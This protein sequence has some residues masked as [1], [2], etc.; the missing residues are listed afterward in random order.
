MSRAE[1]PDP[2]PIARI[3]H[4]GGGTVATFVN[5]P[6]LELRREAVRRAALAALAALDAKLPLEVPMLIGEDVVTGRVFAS[7]DPSS[8]TRIVAHAHEATEAHVDDAV[9]RAE[10]GH[11][12]WSRKPAAERAATLSRAADILRARR[13]ELAALPP[14]GRQAVGR[15]RR[16]RLRG[17]RLPRVLRAGRARAR[18]RQAAAPAAGRAQ[19]AALCRPR[20]H[21]R[22]RAVELPARDRRGHG[23]RRARDRQRGRAQ[24][25]RAGARLRQGRRRR[26]PP[27][28]SRSTRSRCSRAAT[29]PARR[30][31]PTRAS[32]RSSSPAPAPSACRSSSAPRRSSPASVTSSA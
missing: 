16:R 29:R 4:S 19:R 31:S 32:T 22:D 12:A 11:V 30:S 15:G 14:R 2:G 7:V 3:G 8:P 18:G 23:E 28:A 25:R 9:A 17:D 13:L 20:R 21:R 6:L 10:K 5:E 24:A 26:A 1:A 27:A